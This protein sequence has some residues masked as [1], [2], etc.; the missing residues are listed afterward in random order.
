MNSACVLVVDDNRD[1]ANGIAMLLGE[2]S[3]EVQAVYSARAALDALGARRF[4]LVVSDV[5]MPKVSGMDLLGEVRTSWPETKVVLVTAYGT[6]DAAVQAMRAGASDYL[7]KPFDNDELLRVVERT[8]RQRPAAEQELASVVGQVATRV[9]EGDL[10]TGLKGALEVLLGATGADD[11]ELFLCE[12]EGRDPLL[13]VWAGPDGAQL[14]ERTRFEAGTGYPG[15]VA[16]TGKPILGHLFDDERYLRRSV[17]DAGV[18]SMVAVPLLDGENVLG[19]LHVLSRRDDLPEAQVLALLEAAALPIAN[20]VRAE[21]GALRRMVDS[22]CADL[23]DEGRSLRTL[24]EKMRT[25]AGAHAGSLALIDPE[26]GRPNR[27]VSTGPTSLVCAEAEK[28][29]WSNCPVAQ[30]AHGFAAN[31]GR[32]KWPD[33]CRRGLPRRSASPCCVPLATGGKLHGLTVLDFGREGTDNPTGRLVPLMTMAQQLGV[34]LEARQRGLAVDRGADSEA[35]EA[36]AT[37]E[38]ELRCLGAFT[39]LRQGQPIPGEA[40]TRSKAPGLLKLLA[41]KGGAPVHREAI[42]E[43]L[44][45]DADPRHGANRLHGVVHDLRAVIEPQRSTR[46]WV[47]LRN[48]GEFYYLDV[49]APLEVDLVRYRRL[50]ADCL[51][52]APTSA[53]LAQL[54]ALA[55]LYR[56]DLFEDEPFAEWCV[57]EREELRATHQRVLTLLVERHT[58]AGDLEAALRHVARAMAHTPHRD[59]LLLTQMQ[60]FER[61]GRQHEAVDAYRLFRQKLVAELD[62]EPSE[63]AQRLHERLLRAGH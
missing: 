45:P 31:P 46:D 22:V 14:V 41:L 62:A 20:A 56:G 4:D 61:L 27:V 39:I 13:C 40:F 54:E 32:R 25:L 48:R 57:A 50:A 23:D 51:R 19:S 2:A 44:W 47:Y 49:Q 43:H 16:A 26:S 38:L 7:T 8:V 33:P 3:Y 42:I 10:L 28:G 63:A 37:P 36:V 21:L 6:I 35:M 60:L 55:Q 17:V 5:R 11:A 24:L 29:A 52:A 18:R 53:D 34:R 30:A 15:I 58:R 59:D 1:M 12:P 9:C